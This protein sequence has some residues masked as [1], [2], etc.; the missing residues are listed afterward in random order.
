MD[1]DALVGYLTTQ[2]NVESRIGPGYGYSDAARDI[3]A[4][5]PQVADAAGY[6]YAFRYTICRTRPA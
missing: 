1:R 3:D 5:M 2:T 6:K 4:T